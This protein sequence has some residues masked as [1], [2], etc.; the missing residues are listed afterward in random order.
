MLWL[1]KFKLKLML[2]PNKKEAVFTASFFI[3]IR[4]GYSFQTG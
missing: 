4:K 1:K 2:I 3:N